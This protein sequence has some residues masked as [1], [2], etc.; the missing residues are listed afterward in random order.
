MNITVKARHMDA[1][2][3]IRD[4]VQGKA[5]KLER[6]LDSLQSMDVILDLEAEHAVVEM[7]ATAKKKTVFVAKTNHEDMYACIDQCL[8]KIQEQ[9]RRHK[10]KIRDRQGPPHSESM[11][12]A[13]EA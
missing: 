1:T 10:D 3:S 12:P 13:E 5:A 8:H 9:L 6:F 2:D 11:R 4:Y 7:I